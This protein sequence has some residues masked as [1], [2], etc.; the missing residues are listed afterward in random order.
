MI[1]VR[2][3]ENDPVALRLL[4]SPL[5][6][7]LASLSLLARQSRPP[8]PY[9][10]W[11]R[12]IPRGAVDDVLL[13]HACP[14]AF[15]SPNFPLPVPVVSGASIA[16]EVRV[17]RVPCPSP[18][19]GDFR[20]R[21]L[22]YWDQALAPYWS[23]MRAAAEDDLLSRARMLAVHGPDRVLAG[24]GSR[25]RFDRG[26]LTSAS[27]SRVDLPLEGRRLTLVPLLFGRAGGLHADDPLRGV[28]L[29]YQA[30]GAV[31]L[32]NRCLAEPD[33][34]QPS[35]GDPLS[36]L[37]GPSRAKVIRALAMPQ[38][39]TGAAASLGMAQSTVSEHISTLRA[40]GIL[41]RQRS[42][43]TVIYELDRT[44]EALLEYLGTMA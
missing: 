27:H 13:A 32:A 36:L 7:T 25:I 42:G 40:A 6:E 8:W 18:D 43:R 38:T 14:S 1:R 16:D 4:I 10:E 41:R 21:L 34:E 39:I 3:G 26:Q 15:P 35:L 19:P 20:R 12:Q 28:A 30:S 17:M 9:G 2:I 24:L 29:S 31:L 33:R 44:G 22:V 37:V 11:A 5:W 23:A